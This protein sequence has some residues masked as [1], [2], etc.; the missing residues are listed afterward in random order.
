MRLTYEVEIKDI[1]AFNRF[2]LRNSP[3]LRAQRIKYLLFCLSFFAVI[4]GGQS[5]RL[6]S[7]LSLTI[8]VVAASLFSA[9]YLIYSHRISRRRVLKLHPK[10]EN[11]SMLCEHELEIGEGG[12][13]ERT[14]LGERLDAF[15][16][17]TKIEQTDEHAFIFIGSSQA[18]VVPR[19]GVK[20]GD[21]DA[22]MASALKGWEA[23]KTGTG[24]VH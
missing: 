22:F 7:L 5:L 12:V 2:F 16:A 18:H 23:R 15:E 11:R 8:W 1:V 24:T 10:D 6:R 20:E 4:G 21:F 19:N 17:I 13:I 9:A 3:V 14:P